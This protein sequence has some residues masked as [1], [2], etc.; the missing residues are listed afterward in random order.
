MP[1]TI[2]LTGIVATQ[3][4]AITTAEGYSITTFRLASSQRRFDRAQSQWVDGDTNWYNVTAYRH[5][6]D[7]VRSS[8]N[9][10][11]RLVLTGRLHLKEWKS[12]ERSGIS[13]D[14]DV[15]SLGHN[16]FWGRSDFTPVSLKATV[17]TITNGGRIPQSGEVLEA[18]HEHVLAV[19]RRESAGSAA[20]TPVWAPV[21]T[22][23][24]AHHDDE[25]D[26]DDDDD[27]VETPF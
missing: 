13:A 21:V 27:A 15:D 14:V 6:A 22:P 1:D 26:H 23:P 19:A 25:E 8:V 16:M 4:K 2:T 5:L 3:P 20:T 7:N 10:G 12:G 17:P 11:D 18:E 9:K 24:V